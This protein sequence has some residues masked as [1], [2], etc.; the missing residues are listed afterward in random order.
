MME[1]EPKILKPDRKGAKETEINT[2]SS[3]STEYTICAS[4]NETPWDFLLYLRSA[5]D[6]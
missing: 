3:H 5:I 2:N 1:P 6:I 4:E